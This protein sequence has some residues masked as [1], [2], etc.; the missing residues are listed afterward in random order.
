MDFKFCLLSV[1]RRSSCSDHLIIYSRM[2]TRTKNSDDRGR[3]HHACPK[4]IVSRLIPVI[5]GAIANDTKMPVTQLSQFGFLN[6][7]YSALLQQKIQILCILI[8]NNGPYTQ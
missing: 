7:N 1:G 5:T 3:C 8:D 2:R 4:V 6:L